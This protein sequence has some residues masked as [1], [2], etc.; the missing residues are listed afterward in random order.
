MWHS[1]RE[2][3]DLSG[4]IAST[5]SIRVSIPG[6]FTEN[7]VRGMH[8]R[9]QIHMLRDLLKRS[10]PEATDSKL[11]AE[12]RRVTEEIGKDVARAIRHVTTDVTRRK[13]KKGLRRRK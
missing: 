13:Q 4:S 2:T 8:E 11:L 3:T 9:R 1:F 12:M 6:T 10:D 7:L 5:T